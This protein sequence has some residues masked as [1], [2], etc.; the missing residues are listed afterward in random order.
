M[1]SRKVYVSGKIKNLIIFN[2]QPPIITVG[3]PTTTVP[4]CAVLS[5]IRTAGLPQIN[6]VAEPFITTSG[7]PTQTACTSYSC[8]R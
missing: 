7:G 6:T 2:N 4:P 1:Y 3:N 5:P 8:S